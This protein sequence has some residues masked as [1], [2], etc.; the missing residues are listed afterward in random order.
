MRI[1]ITIIIFI[2][3]S[4]TLKASFVFTKNCKQAFHAVTEFRFNDAENAL[5]KEKALYPN[6]LMIEYVQN[7]IYFLK[8]VNNELDNEESF[9][10]NHSNKLIDKMDNC[11]SNSPYK[12]YCIT[13]ILL[14]RSIIFGRNKSYIKAFANLKEAQGYNEENIYN[15]PRFIPNK[16]AKAIMHLGFGS[17]PETYSWVL[18]ILDIDASVNQGLYMLETLSQEVLEHKSLSF[19]QTEALLLSSFAHS[20]LSNK[21][22][23]NQVIVNIFE[24]STYD[25][26]YKNNPL[27]TFA[28]ASYF[29]HDKNNNKALATLVN[30]EEAKGAESFHYLKFLKG[31]SLMYKLDPQ[32]IQSFDAYLRDF[33]GHSYRKFTIQKKAWLLLIYKGKEAYKNEIK[34]VDKYENTILDADKQ[35]QKEFDNNLVPNPY[36]LKSRLFFDGGYYAK[37]LNALKVGNS[38]GEFEKKE[39]HLEYI[40]RLGRIT[41]EW[42]KWETALSYYKKTIQIGQESPRYFAANAAFLAGIIYEKKKDYKNAK[43][44]YNKCLDLD[45]DEYYDSITQKAK[46]GLNRIEK[47]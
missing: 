39:L 9:F 22:S 8:A 42:G 34:K 31:I 1:S 20:N 13:D 15:Y 35:A 36:L 32:A 11:S 38:K 40:Y 12:G 44:M 16:K 43:L 3:T 4:S 6:N 19:L 21:D 47:H 45:F 33:K 46:A 29:Q 5:K 24:S 7:Y 26:I 14:Q 18:N 30:F 2:L 41:D 10:L 25:H 27:L 28:R 17:I 23:S 37:A